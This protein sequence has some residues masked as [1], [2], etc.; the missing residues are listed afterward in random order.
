M[1]DFPVG[2]FF[3]KVYCNVIVVT[4]LS[5]I[6]PSVCY[7]L[8]PAGITR[9]FVLCGLSVLSSAAVIYFVGCN[10]EER[11]MIV[12]AVQSVIAKLRRR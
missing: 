9:F 8:M 5:L 10:R 3:T 11:A 4:L 7:V 1:I 6:V 12:K 2:G